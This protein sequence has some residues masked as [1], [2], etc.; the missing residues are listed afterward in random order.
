MKGGHVQG[1]TER[2]S[3]HVPKV[4]Q[5]GHP[6]AQTKARFDRVLFVAAFYLAAP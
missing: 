3:M 2:A 5:S 6:L 4:E 1:S